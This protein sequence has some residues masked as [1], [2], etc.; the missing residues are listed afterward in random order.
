M[1]LSTHPHRYGEGG[2]ALATLA[3]PCAPSA[4]PLATNAHSPACFRRCPLPDATARA[5]EAIHFRSAK[6]RSTPPARTRVTVNRG[7]TT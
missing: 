2:H 1:R 3:L 7:I 5:G 6:P 4:A